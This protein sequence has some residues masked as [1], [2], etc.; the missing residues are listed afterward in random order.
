MTYPPASVAQLLGIVLPGL[1]AL[2]L[3]GVRKEG[4]R[5]DLSL[6]LG[7]PPFPCLQNLKKKKKKQ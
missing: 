6:P 3:V 1:W 5:M 4:N 7:L 2:S